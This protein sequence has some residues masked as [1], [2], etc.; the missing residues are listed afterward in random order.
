MPSAFSLTGME[1]PYG[2]ACVPRCQTKNALH[3]HARI[4]GAGQICAPD[5]YAAIMQCDAEKYPAG[6]VAA[7]YR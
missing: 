6:L 1:I 3:Y 7:S 2:E 4:G 5:F